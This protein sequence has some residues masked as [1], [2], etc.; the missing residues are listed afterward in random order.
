MRGIFSPIFQKLQYSQKNFFQAQSLLSK[1]KNWVKIAS[2]MSQQKIVKN[3]VLFQLPTGLFLGLVCF[4]PV[5][6]TL[7]FV[8]EKKDFFDV[9]WPALVASEQK[10]LFPVLLG[11]PYFTVQRSQILWYTLEIPENLLNTY[12]AFVPNAFSSPA[13]KEDQRKKGEKGSGKI[14]PFPLRKE[15]SRG[16]E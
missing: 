3:P 2:A 11:I 1:H 12:K 15:E 6:E 5:F 4:N 8:L 7:K 14:V 10:G 9:E 16:K 13:L